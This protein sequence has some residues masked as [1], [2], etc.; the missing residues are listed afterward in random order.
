MGIIK[1]D[2]SDGK[3]V[4]YT[5]KMIKNHMLGRKQIQV[6]MIHPDSA[7]ISKVAIKDE[8][9]SMFKTKAE[10]CTIFGLKSKFGGGRSSGFA[11]IY[12]DLDA[13]KKFD[14]KCALLRDKLLEKP[15]KTRKQKKEIKGRVKRVW[16]TKKTAAAAA[17]P[18]KKK[19]R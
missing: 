5:R 7:N 19:K 14:S 4:L 13:K 18:S 12:D 15:K 11:F 1:P 2:M 6:E 17:G 3:F 10:N 9:S 8:L 16:G